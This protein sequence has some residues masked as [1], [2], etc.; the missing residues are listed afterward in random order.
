MARMESVY[1]EYNVEIDCKARARM[2]PVFGRQRH[3]ADPG[4]RQWPG[5]DRLAGPW[6]HAHR[7]NANGT[8][9]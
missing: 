8:N 1:I 9:Q 6:L 7:V 2:I 3:L 4:G 5:A